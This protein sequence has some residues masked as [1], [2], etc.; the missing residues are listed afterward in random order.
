MSGIFDVMCQQHNTT[1]LNLFV[2]STKPVTLTVCVNRT[3]SCYVILCPEINFVNMKFKGV[4]DRE[5]LLSN[6]LK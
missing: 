5:L 6:L 4:E 2:N 1:A 3:L